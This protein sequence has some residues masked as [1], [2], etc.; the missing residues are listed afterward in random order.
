MQQAIKICFRKYVTFGGR[1]S[2]SEYWY[3]ALFYT[4]ISIVA[5]ILDAIIGLP[6]FGVIAAIVFFLPS[7]AVAVRRLHDTNRSG[8][9]LFFALVP[10]IGVIMLII[11]LA[12]RSREGVNKY[13]PPPQDLDGAMPAHA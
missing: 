9:W 13:G 8:W 1:A 5:N 2:R 4:I 7:L 3:F 6:A 11:W 12:S 10:V